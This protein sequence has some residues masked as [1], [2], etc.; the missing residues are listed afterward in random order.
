MQGQSLKARSVFMGLVA[1]LS[2]TPTA[3]AST[4]RTLYYK[5]NGGERIR[6]GVVDM[7]RVLRIEWSDGP[8]MTYRRLDVDP[9]QAN[10]IDSFGG[11]WCWIRIMMALALVCQ[12]Q[13]VT[14]KFAIIAHVLG[15]G[16]FRSDRSI[17]LIDRYPMTPSCRLLL[18]VAT[19]RW[20][21]QC[22]K[23]A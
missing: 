11:Y 4:Q 8:K 22:C 7:G 15:I 6:V 16:Y 21:L 20:P 2:V 13:A 3:I 5:F 18:P 14:M 12:A 23:V 9:D 10:I 19:T 1:L 17:W